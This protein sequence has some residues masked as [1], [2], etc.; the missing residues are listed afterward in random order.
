MA[1]RGWTE[2][3]VDSDVERLTVDHKDDRPDRQSKP[4]LQHSVFTPE[5]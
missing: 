5:R 3:L 2:A 1:D 4:H